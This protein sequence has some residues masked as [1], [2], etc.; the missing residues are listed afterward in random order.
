MREGNKM[1]YKPNFIKRDR[2][3][4]DKIKK[5][6][7]KGPYSDIKVVRIK[8]QKPRK[9][10]PF[11]LMFR[12]FT[13]FDVKSYECNNGDLYIRNVVDGIILKR[14][15]RMDADDQLTVFKN[16]EE[17]DE[18]IK[19][20]KEKGYNLGPSRI[21]TQKVKRMSLQNCI[22]DVKEDNSTN[23]KPLLTQASDNFVLNN[24][25]A[26]RDSVTGEIDLIISSWDGVS[27]T[28]DECPDFFDKIVKVLEAN[29]DSAQIL[30]KKDFM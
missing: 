11:V 7:T 29:I 10:E 1:S 4:N 28:R 2:F 23:I 22:S 18:F 5:Q 16:R 9:D 19:K 14:Y 12:N 20:A 21:R 8:S 24:Y 30:T 17:F 13:F 15:F 27:F 3:D 25:S 26:R 6:T